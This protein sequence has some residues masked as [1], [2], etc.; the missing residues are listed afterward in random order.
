MPDT[1]ADVTV[2][3][4]TSPNDITAAG[5][6]VTSVATPTGS[7]NPDPEVIRDGVFPPVDSTDPTTEYDTN[8]GTAHANITRALEDIAALV[9]KLDFAISHI[10]RMAAP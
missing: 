6:I 9:D 10:D 7:G 2:D 1:G 4:T 3:S 5:T 8:D